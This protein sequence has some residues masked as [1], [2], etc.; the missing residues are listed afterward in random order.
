[1]S[2]R[3]IKN[4]TYN[5]FMMVVKAI[6]KKGYDQEESIRMAHRLFDELN[7]LGESMQ[8]KVDRILSKEE[9]EAE[10]MASGF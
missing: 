5:N 3:N 6:M 10:C 1:M 9:W 7:P 8:S 4:K 2:M